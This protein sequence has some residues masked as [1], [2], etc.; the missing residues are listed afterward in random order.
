MNFYNSFQESLSHRFKKKTSNDR[1]KNKGFNQTH[2][3]AGDEEQF[4]S[5]VSKKDTKN[6]DNELFYRTFCYIFYKF[7]KGIFVQIRE[8]NVATFLPF[9][10]ANYINEWS[11]RVKCPKQYVSFQHFIRSN[12]IKEGYDLRPHK[13]VDV[14]F[15]DSTRKKK[16]DGVVVK[17]ERTLYVIRSVI[18]D[19]NPTINKEWYVMNKYKKNGILGVDVFA[20]KDT[21]MQRKIHMCKR[22]HYRFY[23]VYRLSREEFLVKSE[24]HVNKNKFRWY[25]NNG[26]IRCE[27][28]IRENDSGI[29]NIHDMLIT[30]CTERKIRDC[31][32]FINKRDFPILKKNRTEAYDR[33]FGIDAPM[34]SHKYKN[35]APIL[36]MVSHKKFDD[37]VIP[38]WEDW[39]QSNPDKYF[40]KSSHAYDAIFCPWGD[41]VPTAIFRGQTSGV[42]RTNSRIRLCEM[43]WD[44]IDAKITKVNLRLRVNMQ[45]SPFAYTYDV[46]NARLS[47][48]ALPV[49]I[50]KHKYIIN[51][52]GHV[53]AYRLSYEL[54]YGSVILLADC[55]YKLWYMD[56]LKPYV[57]YIPIKND[58]SDL[59]SKVNWCIQHD[60]ECEVIA[61]NAKQF[62]KT[63]LTKDNILNYLENTL[64]SY[65]KT[66][67]PTDLLEKQQR[68]Q[69][70]M[71]QNWG[72]EN[73]SINWSEFMATLNL[74][75]EKVLKFKKGK[76]VS[77]GSLRVGNN[78]IPMV[79]KLVQNPYHQQ[80]IG[81]EAINPIGVPSFATTY[82]LPSDRF[83][84]VNRHANSTTL[85]EFVQGA[86]YNWTR[87]K[88]IFVQ[89]A[90]TMEIAQSKIGLFHNDLFPWNVMIVPCEQPIGYMSYT[91]NPDYF[92]FII[93]FERAQFTKDGHVY[94][95]IQN[96]I[97]RHASRDILTLFFGTL[98]FICMSNA[99]DSTTFISIQRILRSIS[100][101]QF[102]TDIMRIC[103]I[104]TFSLESIRK[105]SSVIKQYN[106]ILNERFIGLEKLTPLHWIKLFDP[107]FDISNIHYRSVSDN[108]VMQF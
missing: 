81:T 100:H 69:F 70:E 73:P 6:E 107:D 33:L 43:K 108:R 31:D 59:Q 14:R 62:H 51:L 96:R 24:T 18:Y 60:E 53:C 83:V 80:F 66:F 15:F 103:D 20:S 63:Y 35:Y 25:G 71:M 84:L 12:S 23:Q 75:F 27:N 89:I 49:H 99:V 91:M 7:K 79:I 56:L 58:L 95:G 57:H 30:L 32:F 88:D 8:N 2:F 16:P 17:Q 34:V 9:S 86:S 4:L 5:R 76:V 1:Y 44:N 10:N 11:H 74:T 85:Q 78:D 104:S 65:S 98:H 45:S 19:K 64:K 22:N 21:S 87:M 106:F 47:R 48:K 61:N 50:A 40:P 36:S 105:L 26:L 37:I 94:M 82:Y 41:K 39:S 13:G 97:E 67:C 101:T 38:T 93:D 55:D 3:T 54:S 77:A 46:G 28:P 42:E 29:C 72:P 92:P 102:M 68:R 90:F 52:P